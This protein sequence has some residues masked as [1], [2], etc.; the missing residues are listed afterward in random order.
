MAI[1]KRYDF[2]STSHQ[3]WKNSVFKTYSLWQH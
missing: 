3:Q 2:P 1:K